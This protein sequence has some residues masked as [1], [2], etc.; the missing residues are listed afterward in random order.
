MVLGKDIKMS[1]IRINVT[2]Q[3][4]DYHLNFYLSNNSSKIFSSLQ[5][6]NK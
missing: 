2:C 5:N 6:S 4:F 3:N 1:E